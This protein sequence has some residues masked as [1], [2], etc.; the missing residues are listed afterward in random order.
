MSFNPIDPKRMDISTSSYVSKNYSTSLMK[1]FDIKLNFHEY[2]DKDYYKIFISKS[3]N[4]L[5][6]PKFFNKQSNYKCLL[7][8]EFDKFIL[9]LQ[10]ICPEFIYLNESIQIHFRENKLNDL[11]DIFV[12]KIN[13]IDNKRL[14]RLIV[15]PI[16]IWFYD[17]YKDNQRLSGHKNV[18][19]INNSLETITYFEPY[20]I[21]SNKKNVIILNVLKKY[22]TTLLPSYKFINAASSIYFGNSIDI[23]FYVNDIYDNYYIK[24]KEYENHLDNIKLSFSAKEFKLEKHKIKNKIKKLRKQI[25]K[26]KPEN[27]DGTNMSVD[28]TPDILTNNGQQ[29]MQELIEIFG[30]DG[31]GGHCVGWSLYTVFL[32]FININLFTKKFDTSVS[33]SSFINNLFLEKLNGESL[34]PEVLSNMIRH[35]IQ[36]V[37]NFNDYYKDLILIKAKS[38][39]VLHITFNT[40]GGFTVL[41]PKPIYDKIDF[42]SMNLSNN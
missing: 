34:S 16:N 9:I 22:Y 37:H 23:D 7:D 4:K 38:S 12:P 5:Y 33:L 8:S 30:D 13:I 25:K 41:P 29:K 1:E 31:I 21:N 35:F 15:I 32:T 27:S 10:N 40:Q 28:Y 6:F 24:I 42:S 3:K 39:K 14:P 2:K 18:I 19:I 11:N 36:Y 20:G 17:K 26:I